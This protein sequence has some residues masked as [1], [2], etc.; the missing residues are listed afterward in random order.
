[1]WMR[2]F[3]NI[4]NEILRPS[5]DEMGQEISLQSDNWRKLIQQLQ[6][7]PKI[8]LKFEVQSS[9]HFL[10]Y[11]IRAQLTAG[12]ACVQKETIQPCRLLGHN[13]LRKKQ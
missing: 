5:V 9:L 7:T 2:I 13:L 6:I 8:S 1:M 10:C 12:P 3:P 11:G 4:A